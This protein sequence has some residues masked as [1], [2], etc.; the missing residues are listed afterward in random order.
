MIN[1]CVVNSSSVLLDEWDLS[2]RAEDKSPN[3]R[4][5]Y[6]WSIEKLSEYLKK[7][8]EEAT[9]LDRDGFRVW[10]KDNHH[11]KS[12]GVIDAALRHYYRW[13]A[14][15]TGNRDLADMA[16]FRTKMPP[17]KKRVGPSHE[18][19]IEILKM[20][21]SVEEQALIITLYSTGARIGELC[22]N[23]TKGT[24]GILIED[25]D[26]EKMT[27]EIRTGEKWSERVAKLGKARTL[28]YMHL[29]EWAKKVM[30]IYIGERTQGPIFTFGPSEAYTM[31]KRCAKRVGLSFSPHALRH[32]CCT[33]LVQKGVGIEYA[34][35]VLG[36]SSVETTRGYLHL[37]TDDL[38]EMRKKLT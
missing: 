14:R 16:D 29:A 26:A 15:K 34:G 8:L 18:E 6:R 10:V 23:S 31:V 20:C 35:Q 30:Q 33:T 5:L 37:T 11:G 19:I 21:R 4:K 9:T 32:S 2:M 3:T 27:A 36:H 38:A 13:L 25:F 22:G 7:P 12:I 28:I 17:S 24:R 1:L